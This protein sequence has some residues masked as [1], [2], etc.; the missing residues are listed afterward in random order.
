MRPSRFRIAVDV[1][2]T[3]SDF[4]LVDPDGNLVEAKTP[5]TP[6]NPAEALKIGL[7]QLATGVNHTLRHMLHSSHL[8]IHGTTVALNT[9]LQQRGARTGLICTAGFRDSLEIRLGHREDRYNFRLPPPLILV[10]RFLRRPVGERIDK[11]GAVLT[12]LDEE[13]V[14]REIRYLK[15]QNVEAVAVSLL[16]SFLNPTHERRIAALLS[17]LFPTAYV[18]ISADVAPQIREYDR[19]STT[20]L[21]SY[22]GPMFSRYIADTEG[23]LRSYGF[24]GPIRYVQSN[25][26]LASGDTLSKAPILA[27]D[28]GP[29]TAPSAS[30]FVCRE[31]EATNLISC[32]MGGTS[33]DTCLITDGRP[34]IVGSA[35]VHG[36]RLAVPMVNIHAI[37]AGGGSIA[38]L[39]H[40]ILTVG[41]ASAEAFPGP[42]CYMRGG[43]EPTV[44]DADVVLGYLNPRALL[45]GAFE[46]DSQLAHRAI[47]DRIARPLSL[48]VEEAAL[49][50]FEIV[51]RNMADALSAVSLERGHDPRDF[52]MVVGGGQGPV[53][54]AYLARELE[55]PIV[56]IPRHASTFCAL[57][58]LVSDLR[59]D[60]RRSMP[61]RLDQADP[62]RIDAALSDLEALGLLDLDREDISPQ[63]VDVHRSLEM[64]YLGQ[65]FEIAVDASDLR[66]DLP[67]CSAEMIERFHR[68]HEAEYGYRL[69]GSEVEIVTACVTVT[70]R[71]QEVHLT[72]REPDP[73]TDL[74]CVGTRGMLYPG[75]AAR[76]DTPVFDGRAL[77]CGQV[78]GGPAVVEE[79][80]TTILVPPEF[81]L[82]LHNSMFT[83]VPVA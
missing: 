50:I 7:T 71:V 80:H 48:A 66:F 6:A 54:A 47:E 14:R 13:D 76:V 49:G 4:L 69:D 74:S 65:V 44:T 39:H 28:S 31:L 18:S 81:K 8:A 73:A 51:N 21:N 19:T 22:L 40:G 15:S 58:A 24:E 83:L 64:R 36:Y 55:I 9:L 46:I 12:P 68:A 60:H 25:G 61:L 52:T 72:T 11:T 67:D 82:E 56:V 1:G 77:R 33:F 34:D 59:H 62:S 79:P 53:H 27:L 45:G 16:W 30:T 3:F 5:S 2:G 10:P 29:A 38:W 78:V 26:G 35:D 37:G 63:A 42:A 20:V 41:P 17:D 70:G 32:D 57:G 75:T 23:A 43:T